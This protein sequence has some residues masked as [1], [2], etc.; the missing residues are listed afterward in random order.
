M[1]P[2]APPLVLFLFGELIFQLQY[3]LKSTVGGHLCEHDFVLADWHRRKVVHVVRVSHT[4]EGIPGAAA[5]V[6]HFSVL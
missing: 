3:S 4:R 2:G 5:D 6:V 1:L